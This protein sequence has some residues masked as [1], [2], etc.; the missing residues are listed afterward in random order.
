MGFLDSI[1]NMFSGGQM[2]G[3]GDMMNYLRQ[4]PGLYDQL[5]PYIDAS[6]GMLP[7]YENTLNQLQNGSYVNNAMKNSYQSPLYQNQMN[8]S[9]N[10]ANQAAAAGGTLGTPGAQQTA[11]RAAQALSAQ[12]Q[13]NYL[14]NVMQGT[15]MGLQGTQG[16]IG[17]GNQDQLLKT[18]GLAENLQN[19]G[20]MQYGQDVSQASGL[21]GM[22]G[23]LGNGVANMLSPGMGGILGGIGRTMGD[24]GFGNQMP[25]MNPWQRSG[26]GSYQG[27]VPNYQGYVPDFASQDYNQ[28]NNFNY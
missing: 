7:G 1:E 25:Q 24:F 12:D 15:G 9:M 20:S 13:N 27:Y 11:E 26:V 2:N 8:A 17:M 21:N 22:L 4:I 5:N 14:Q 10:A 6:K 28:L 19:M 16:L 23:F 18:Q 3:Y